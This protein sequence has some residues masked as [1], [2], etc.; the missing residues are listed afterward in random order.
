MLLITGAQQRKEEAD[1]IL[2]RSLHDYDKA[3]YDDRNYSGTILIDG[4]EVAQTLQCCHCQ[5]HFIN[6]KIPGKERGWCTR[7]NGPVC[8]KKECDVCLPFMR[9]VENIE[10]G[11]PP[12]HSPVVVAVRAAF[13]IDK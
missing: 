3:H 9:W 1:P 7:C 5:K 12:G 2:Y 10:K 8:P 11:L 6:L 13:G 4:K